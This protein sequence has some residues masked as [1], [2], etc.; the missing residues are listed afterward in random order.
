M[1]GMFPQARLL[2]SALAK[3]FGKIEV[4]R[5]HAVKVNVYRH[6]AFQRPRRRLRAPADLLAHHGL[7]ALRLY[8][9]A[10]ESYQGATASV[11]TFISLVK[12]AT[13]DP[14]TQDIA[15]DL[16]KNAHEFDKALC[17][18]SLVNLLEGIRPY[19]LYHGCS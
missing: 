19:A 3:L 9:G 14:A 15:I 10:G 18:V 13:F 11:N 12:N 6:S 17:P 8:V 5:V 16:Y 1:T 7:T 4:R 2:M